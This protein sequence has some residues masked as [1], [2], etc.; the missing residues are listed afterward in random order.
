MIWPVVRFTYQVDPLGSPTNPVP[1]ALNRAAVEWAASV[2]AR[3]GASSVSSMSVEKVS[4]TYID[5]SEPKVVAMLLM[6][7]IREQAVMQF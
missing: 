4:E 3:P 7:H 6:R 5:Q 1:A 2:Y